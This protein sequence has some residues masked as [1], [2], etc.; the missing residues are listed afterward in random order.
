[1]TQQCT[2]H[3]KMKTNEENS[4]EVLKEVLPLLEEQYDFSNDA[5]FDTSEENMLMKK[6]VKTRFCYVADPYCGIRKTEHTWRC[7]R[8]YGDSWQ[9][10]ICSQN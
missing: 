7:Y 1:M 5:L 2:A 6:D 8:D 10:R 9:R 3:K 4:L